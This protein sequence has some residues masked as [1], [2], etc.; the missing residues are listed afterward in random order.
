MVGLPDS[1]SDNALVTPTAGH[2]LGH[3]I[4]EKQRLGDELQD[5]L[6]NAI[7]TLISG[8]YWKQFSTEFSVSDP[9]QL[10][11]D[12]FAVQAWENS[13]IW[14]MAQ[15]EELFCDLVG[16]FCFRES[17]LHAFEYLLAPWG[18][19]REERYPSTK[20]RIS[21]LV[22]AAKANAIEVPKDFSSNFSA[23]PTEPSLLLQISDEATKGFVPK[24]AAIASEIAAKRGLVPEPAEIP[25]IA[26][27]LKK[28][29]PATGVRHFQNIIS[30]GWLLRNDMDELW[31]ADYP[32]L[33][34]EPERKLRIL[35]ELLLKSLEVYEL[36]KLQGGPECSEAQQSL[37][38]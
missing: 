8:K 18:M 24:L 10:T 11:T 36:E 16:L 9:K 3:N 23:D 28:C 1:E 17:Y 7:L 32:I 30:A 4:W 34:S 29:V 15:S 38:Y 26:A 22:E 5:D 20:N 6:V 33:R 35:N 2:E 27:D 13:Y 37:S 19:V 21:V 12:L 14:S 25:Q 31:I